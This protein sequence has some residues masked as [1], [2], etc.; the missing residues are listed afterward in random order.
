MQHTLALR[1][2]TRLGTCRQELNASRR[3]RGDVGS[4]YH[5]NEESKQSLRLATVGVRR[6]ND[7]SLLSG[8]AVNVITAA[9][10]LL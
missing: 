5:L 2:F 3:L 9:L 8:V 4:V 6:R 1:N 7:S 10:S